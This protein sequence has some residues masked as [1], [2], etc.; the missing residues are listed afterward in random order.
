MFRAI[1]ETLGLK[2]LERV[3]AAELFGVVVEGREDDGAGALGAEDQADFHGS[4]AGGWIDILVGEEI[5]PQA[6]DQDGWQIGEIGG[7]APDVIVLQDR[8]DFVIGLA[9]VHTVLAIPFAVLITFS[10]FS[11]WASESEPPK[12]VKSWLKT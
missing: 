2:G 9:I 11:A 12:T 8:D 7:A 3:V 4:V 1:V 10:I 6:V 5:V